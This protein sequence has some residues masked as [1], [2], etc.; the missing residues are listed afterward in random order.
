MSCNTKFL[1]SILVSGVLLLASCGEEH[2]ISESSST[3]SIEAPVNTERD[4]RKFAGTELNFIANK[5]PWID[6]IRPRLEQ[7]SQLTGITVNLKVYP[8]EQ[9]RTKRSVELMS[10]L[11]NIDVFMIMPGNSLDEYYRNG[12]IEELNSL[13]ESPELGWPEYDMEDVFDTALQVGVRDGNNYTLPIMLE[14]SLLAYNRDIFEAYDIQVPHS[15]EQL[16]AA[17]QAVFEDSGGQVYGITMRGKKSAA[18]SQWIDFVRSFGG[19][20][21]D[22]NGRAALHS[23]EAIAATQLYGRLLREYGPPSAPTNSWY[24][25]TAMFMQGRAA[26]IYDAS[27]F[28]SNYEDPQMSKIADKVGYATIPA[29]PAGSTPH[30]SS[31]GLAISTVSKHKQAAWYFMQWATNRKF[32][33]EGL[34]KGIPAAR[35]SAWDSPIFKASETSPEWTRASLD[36]YQRASTRWNPPVVDV[37]EGREIAGA[38]IVAAILGNEIYPVAEQAS[39]HLNSLIEKENMDAE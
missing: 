27:V 6:L 39:Q 32:A 17:A 14:T 13:M 38:A 33:L 11:S 10:G 2:R 24:E 22:K 12:W 7:F 4:I 37:N 36:S 31:W 3:G 5:H 19:D 35:N 34:L 26:M 20:W 21:L 25:S 9:F 30:V 1:L 28:K 18:T 8:E 29:G 23:P 15:M 16:E